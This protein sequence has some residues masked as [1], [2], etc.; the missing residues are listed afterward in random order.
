MMARSSGTFTSETARTAGK[1]RAV[2]AAQERRQRPT[3]AEA[4]ARLAVT[5]LNPEWIAYEHP[6]HTEPGMEQYIDVA[7]QMDGQ[8]IAVEV[9]GSKGWHG[10]AKMWAYDEIKARWL[11]ANG[12]ALVQLNGKT[13]KQTP[14]QV[15]DEII[16]KMKGNLL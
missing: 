3:K 2:F 4:K 1:R 11:Y 8:L 9:D 7:F 12:W 16:S 5:L 10:A 6:I 15:A 14:A 13:A